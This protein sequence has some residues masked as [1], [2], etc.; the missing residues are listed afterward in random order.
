MGRQLGEAF[1][2][3]IR[4]AQELF[5]PWLVTD[6]AR[7]E[8]ALLRLQ[9]LLREYC[10][11]VLEE[12]LGMAEGAGLPALVGLGYRLFNQV[13]MYLN[14][15]CSVVFLRETDRGPLLGRNCDLRAE[16]LRFQLCHVRRPQSEPATIETTYVGLAGGPCLTEFGL[17]IAGASAP[18]AARGQM[19]L[20]YPV[21][22]HGIVSR[23][24]S[25]EDCRR[26]L[27]QHR[28]LGKPANIIL[29][30]DGGDSA[31]LELVPG[32]EPR[33]VR[34]PR[35]RSWQACTNFLV[36]EPAAAGAPEYVANAYARYGRLTHLLGQRLAQ[37]TLNGLH[38]L[39]VDVAQ[40]GPVC[41]A[42][43]PLLTAYSQVMDLRARCMYLWPGHPAECEA[44]VVSL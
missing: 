40:P 4:E 15:G 36:S 2:E 35:Q 43:S 21:L 25:V 27:A 23:S 7:Y 8:P 33:E 22:M 5:A 19:G 42:G 26:V 6:S 29:A 30:D 34:P 38:S 32:L 41:P 24:R 1:R 10:P 9:E 20:P 16:E 13:S 31:L 39:L 18:A 12:A 3:P 11:S 37:H 44:K 28:F 17:G 14:P